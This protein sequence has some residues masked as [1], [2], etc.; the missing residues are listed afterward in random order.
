MCGER[1]QEPTPRAQHN[2]DKS[3]LPPFSVYLLSN[4]R[5]IQYN[6]IQYN[7]IQY[8]TALPPMAIR[9]Q[10]N[11]A[12]ST[13][14]NKGSFHPHIIT[15][16]ESPLQAP[17]NESRHCSLHVFY[18]LPPSVFV[19]PNQIPDAHVFGET[20]LEAPLEHVS[21]IRGSLV[22]LKANPAVDL[23]IHLR[24]QQPDPLETHRV[25]R[26]E[27]PHVGWTCRTSPA[28]A[29]LTQN[30]LIPAR[31]HADPQDTTFI[32]LLHS[33]KPLFLAVPIGRSQDATFVQIGTVLCVL[34]SAVWITWAVLKSLDRI[35]RYDAKGKRRRS[36]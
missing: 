5:T 9:V 1:K 20:D 17:V 2:F 14:H 31:Y 28:P 7:T 16:I 15:T 33:S 10:G 18:T 6:T 23:P 4:K 11:S 29:W 34:L 8:N 19:D 30:P 25:I 36:E 35:R 26:I 21:E 22:I 24:Y 13:L 3:H 12:S 32:P 27:A